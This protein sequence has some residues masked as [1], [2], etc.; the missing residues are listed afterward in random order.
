MRMPLVLKSIGNSVSSLGVLHVLNDG[1]LASLPLLLPFMQRDLGLGFESIGLLSSILAF[2]GVVLALPSARMARRFGG[3]RVLG[4]ALL[5]YSV[6]FILA[7]CASGL[8]S[9]SV[10]FALAS[11]GFGLFHPIA[12]ALVAHRSS[13]QEVGKKMGDFT[14]VGDLGRIGIAAAATFLVAA[15]GWR[16][17]VI[18]YGV[19]PLLIFALFFRH[20]PVH[21]DAAAQ[22]GAKP[23]GLR[24]S[25]NFIFAVIAG[26]LDALASSS[27]FIFIPFLLVH[28]G[29]PTALLGALSGA[30]FVGNMLGKVLVG[31]VVDRLGCFCVFVVSEVVMAALLFYLSSETSTGLIALLSVLLGAVT[32][33]TVPVINTMVTNSVPDRALYEKAF[34]IVSFVGGVAAVVAPYVYGL[35]AE[36]FGIVAVFHLCACFALLA[37]IPGSLNRV[38]KR[39]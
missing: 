31:R 20:T 9:L 24:C 7:G 11:I 26:G 3:P 22:V 36:R 33:G 8:V 27:I 13:A 18:V 32:K 29:I 28:R 23:H 25:E 6:A 15:L 34:G 21:L 1:F 38:M 37:I 35:V 2:A 12:F 19:L 10:S 5:L 4:I 17:T 30:F 14:A 16:E 39:L